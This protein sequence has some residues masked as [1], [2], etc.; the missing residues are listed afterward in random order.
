[1]EDVVPG[2]PRKVGLQPISLETGFPESETAAALALRKSPTETLF[3]NGFY[4][5]LL[6]LCKLPHLFVKAVWYLYGCFHIVS[7]IMLYGK[8]SSDS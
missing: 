8:M 4:R 5:P 6:S 3:D 7:H 2:C 1:V